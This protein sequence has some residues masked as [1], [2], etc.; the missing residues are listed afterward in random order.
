VTVELMISAVIKREGGFVNDPD[1]MGGPTNFGITQRMLAS[2]R[3]HPVDVE[4]VKNLQP[5]EAKA[6]YRKVFWI[7][8][9]F[10][11]LPGENVQSVMFDS[12]VNHGPM[13]AIKLLQRAVGA[14]E[15]GILGPKTIASAT[16]WNPQRLCMRILAAR[17]RYYGRI[18]SDHPAQS[19]FA[20]GWA[21][22]VADF[23]EE[24]A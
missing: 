10:T 2:W 8:P 9:G 7:D 20:A 18:V 15:D 23:I 19:K 1:D 13:T 4:E 14:F 6:I 12:A 16:I 3:G 5:E 24:L 22:R 21:D 11:K 17:V